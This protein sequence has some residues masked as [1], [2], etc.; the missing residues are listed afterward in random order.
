[1]FSPP[2]YRENGYRLCSSRLGVQVYDKTNGASED[3]FLG[4]GHVSLLTIPH[5]LWV[6][7]EVP[8][9]A[10]GVVRLKLKAV[11]FGAQPEACG[12]V[13]TLR[14]D[15]ALWQGGDGEGVGVEVSGPDPIMWYGVATD[16]RKRRRVRARHATGVRQGN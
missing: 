2:M 7:A 3:I 9:A 10:G 5:K 8:L 14:E 15:V 6:P 11:S 16:G 12:L 13:H 4:G 1:M